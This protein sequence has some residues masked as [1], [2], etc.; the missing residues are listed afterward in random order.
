MHCKEAVLGKGCLPLIGCPLIKF[1]N[2]FVEFL[3]KRRCPE[4][5]EKLRKSADWK[6]VTFILSCPF[7]NAILQK[8]PYSP[9]ENYKLS[10]IFCDSDSNLGRMNSQFESVFWSTFGKIGD[11]KVHR[12]LVAKISIF[13]TH[14]HMIYVSFWVSPDFFSLDMFVWIP[15]SLKKDAKTRTKIYFFGG[16]FWCLKDGPNGS[17][18][19][20][21]ATRSFQVYLCF[22]PALIRIC[23]A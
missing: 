21:S 12:N 2:F 4:K 1:R 13:D 5:I 9:V 14:T 11:R 17:R 8:L 23:P 22:C 15:H 18:L 7:Y 19:S 20:A 6:N 16:Q 3:E 10:P